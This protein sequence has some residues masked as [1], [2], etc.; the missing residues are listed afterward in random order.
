MSDIPIGSIIN[1]TKKCRYLFRIEI[2]LRNYTRRI[3]KE[4]L[5]YK[6]LQ[7]KPNIESIV[8]CFYIG[9]RKT[10]YR[11]GKVFK[12]FCFIKQLFYNK[13]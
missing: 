2:R 4:L 6:I 1:L 8:S 11:S 12:L 3:D 13:T 10:K 9:E 5:F 7:D